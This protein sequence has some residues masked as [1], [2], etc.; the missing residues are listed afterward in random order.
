M[1]EESCFNCYLCKF[2]T[3]EEV[4]MNEHLITFHNIE[5]DS[6]LGVILNLC[7]STP[8]EYKCITCN[9]SYCNRTY[10]I[11]HI[12]KPDPQTYNCQKCNKSFDY[13]SVLKRHEASCKG[14]PDSIKANV[15]QLDKDKNIKFDASHLKKETLVKMR[16]SMG[17]VMTSINIF[18][19]LLSNPKNRCISKHSFSHPYSYI[20][21]GDNKWE[22]V[23]DSYLY[24]ILISSIQQYIHRVYDE[25]CSLHTKDGGGNFIPL[26][27]QRIEDFIQNCNTKSRCRDYLDL[28]H[29]LKEYLVKDYLKKT[30]TIPTE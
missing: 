23:L 14:S 28:T 6:N 11:N 20:Y 27:I 13:K 15:F 8:G 2:S 17:P 3:N 5:P 29:A 22:T 19:Y 4:D 30:K 26:P 9:K 18:N 25:L 10:L 16:S 1:E 12:C 24:P 21:N 7:K